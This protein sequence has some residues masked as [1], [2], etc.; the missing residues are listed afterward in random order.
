MYWCFLV[1]GS[2]TLANKALLRGAIKDRHPEIFEL[3]TIAFVR[4][5]GPLISLELGRVCRRG[6]FPGTT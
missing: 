2:V 6:S 1:G 5:K 3:I 4:F